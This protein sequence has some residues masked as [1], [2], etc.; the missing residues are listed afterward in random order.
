MSHFVLEQRVCYE[1]RHYFNQ[2]G[3]ITRAC[4]R[5]IDI[6]QH[7]GTGYEEKRAVHKKFPE[8]KIQKVLLWTYASFKK[9]SETELLQNVIANV[10]G[11]RVFFIHFK[12]YVQG[13]KSGTPVT[14]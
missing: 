13:L 5:G 1:R 3:A 14:N 6:G 7:H 9:S 4:S 10:N 2:D 8:I 11:V 12:S